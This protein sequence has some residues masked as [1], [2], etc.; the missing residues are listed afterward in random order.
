[1]NGAGV[2]LRSIMVAVRSMI[3]DDLHPTSTPWLVAAVVSMAAEAT[4]S[5]QD[6]SKVTDHADAEEGSEVGNRIVSCLFGL[7]FRLDVY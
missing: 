1:M 2:S 3:S 6:S 7:T 4:G 5:K